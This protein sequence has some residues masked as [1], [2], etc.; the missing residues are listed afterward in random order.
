MPGFASLH[1]DREEDHEE[2]C[3]FLTDFITL[4]RLL[5]EVTAHC[6]YLQGTRYCQYPGKN[7]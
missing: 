4:V 6:L 1:A 3:S 5:G 7:M 2:L